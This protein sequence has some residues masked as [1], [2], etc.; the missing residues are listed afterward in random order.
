MY[1]SRLTY[2]EQAGSQSLGT[3]RVMTTVPDWA[4][5]VAV[6]MNKARCPG[7]QSNHWD[8]HPEDEM[9]RSAVKPLE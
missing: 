5:K 7:Q 4:G 1:K 8:E 9:P 3:V 2:G 6:M